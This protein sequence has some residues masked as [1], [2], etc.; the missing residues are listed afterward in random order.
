MKGNT[1][2][3]L[4]RLVDQLRGPDGCPW[5]RQ[6]SF[7]SLKPMLLE[8]AYEV[9]EAM[10]NHD[11]K[12]F[13]DELGDLLFQI[14]FLSQ[15]AEK[16]GFFDIEDVISE[17][18]NKMIRRHPHVFGED[19]VNDSDQVL[20]SWEAI[21]RKERTDKIKTENSKIQ[22]NSILGHLPT[23]PALL[24][25]H[26][27]T[28]KVSRVGFNWN[29]FDEILL[30]LEEEIGELKEAMKCPNN[31]QQRVKVEEEI[32]DLLFVMVNI[33]RFLKIDPETALRKTNYK[34]IQRFQF[35]EESLRKVG[36][37]FKESSIEEMEQFWQKAKSG[38]QVK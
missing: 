32:G 22:S 4:V 24:M 25:A 12:A 20:E 6:Q 23:L 28:S 37:N 30:K 10:D 16:E 31:I 29:K 27:V 34:F 15:M 17:V 7:D 11:N 3:D 26:K 36:K 14:V 9:L 21:K 19:E 5:D 1:F 38:E 33:A 2:Q 35:V 13:C 18:L 8:E